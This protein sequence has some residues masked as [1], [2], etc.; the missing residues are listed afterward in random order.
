[1]CSRITLPTLRFCR[2]LAI[3]RARIVSLAL[4]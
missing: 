2:V 3:G 4:V 1:L